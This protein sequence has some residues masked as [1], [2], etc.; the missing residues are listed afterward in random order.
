MGAGEPERRKEEM[1]GQKVRLIS[2]YYLLGKW[3]LT[4]IRLTQEVVKW[5]RSRWM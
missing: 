1:T 5:Q 3:F 2:I 4:D